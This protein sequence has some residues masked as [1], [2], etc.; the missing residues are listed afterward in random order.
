M[1]AKKK[2]KAFRSA[3]G[4]DNNAEKNTDWRELAWAN[5]SRPL[6][7]KFSIWNKWKTKD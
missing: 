5:H 1:S 3:S 7:L 4:E 2:K 6:G